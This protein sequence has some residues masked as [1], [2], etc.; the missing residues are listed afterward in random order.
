MLLRKEGLVVVLMM[1]RR[2]E[3]LLLL[4][5]KARIGEGGL[6]QL[7]KVLEVLV[8]VLVLVLLKM[9]QL[10]LEVRLSIR[11]GQCAMCA[12]NYITHLGL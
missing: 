11:G 2:G 4:V 7:A 9:R 6:L 12:S 5:W 10:L 1:T 8:L 3:L